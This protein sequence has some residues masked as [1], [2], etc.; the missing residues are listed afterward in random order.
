MGKVLEAGKINSVSGEAAHV[1]ARSGTGLGMKTS[2]P[3]GGSCSWVG[4][5]CGYGHLTLKCSLVALKSG[6]KC[7]RLISGF[8]AVREASSWLQNNGMEPLT[9]CGEGRQDK[10]SGIPTLPLGSSLRQPGEGTCDTGHHRRN[11]TRRFRT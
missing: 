1:T 9:W 3:T 5:G 4:H 10:G 8:G 7:N 6:S 2:R 11:Q